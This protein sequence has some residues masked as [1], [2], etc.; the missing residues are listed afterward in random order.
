MKMTSSIAAIAI[1]S[2][3]L[4]STIA[5][6]HDDHEPL[7]LM[8]S[9]FADGDS[10]PIRFTCDGE[11]ISPPLSWRGIPE[12]TESLVVIM[13]HMPSHKPKPDEVRHTENPSP[14]LQ[15]ATTPKLRAPEGL[16][17]Y[18]GMYNI[19]AQISGVMAGESAGT[20][21]NNVVNNRNEYTPPCS[22]GPGEKSYTFHLYALSASLEI[23][24]SDNNVSEAVLRK[25]MDGLVLDSDSLT[26]NF[27]R[28]YS[29]SSKNHIE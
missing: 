22:K 26:V 29:T 20:L 27:E 11:R 6:A 1:S 8:S 4:V 16:R 23:I 24:P 5:N 7:T 13:D 14:P 18:W 12:G 10:L 19:S 2:T 3:L 17:W 21:G 15:T 9:A 28:R 25:S